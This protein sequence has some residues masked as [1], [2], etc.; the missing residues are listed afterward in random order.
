MA[1]DPSASGVPPDTSGRLDAPATHRNR[2]AILEVLRKSIKRSR[3]R[4]LEIASGSGQ[5]ACYFA[6]NWPAV[7]WWPSDIEERNIDS[8]DAWVRHI[9]VENVKPARVIDVTS[10]AWR[11]GEV[12]DAWA[13]EFDFIFCANMIHIAPWAAVTG[14]IEGASKR[15]V[16]GG[17]L[18]LYGPFMI[19]GAHT[20]PSNQSFDDSLK[21]RDPEWGIRDL[22]DVQA[23]AMQHGFNLQHIT[24]MPAN[25]LT[26][27][28]RLA[29][30]D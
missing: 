16:P 1:R 7:T 17:A 28:L 30:L 20:A 18:F 14:L 6:Q 29:G 9:G 26:L 19:N 23:E 27:E 11:S 13:A 10:A 21:L 12:L 15:L 8:I 3:P 22:A 25:N 2:D 5:H 24:E 4:I